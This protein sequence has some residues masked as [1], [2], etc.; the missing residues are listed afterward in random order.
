MKSRH[1]QFSL[2]RRASKSKFLSVLTTPAIGR[3]VFLC[4]ALS[5]II[6]PA[7]S[8]TRPIVKESEK[9]MVGHRVSNFK[10]TDLEGR[11]VALSDFKDKGVIVLF[12]MGKGCPVA[13]L[14][15]TEL[16]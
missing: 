13:N 11:K 1:K 14:Y 7:Q 9:T 15:L 8:A 10:L 2:N 3:A 4:L 6:W 5:G 16:K 12:V